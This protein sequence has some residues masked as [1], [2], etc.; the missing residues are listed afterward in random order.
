M[1][2]GVLAGEIALHAKLGS[3][4]VGGALGLP[5]GRP[6]PLGGEC[7][8]SGTSRVERP[9][10]LVSL[11]PLRSHEL[12]SDPGDYDRPVFSCL[13]GSWRLSSHVNHVSG[14]SLPS[15]PKEFVK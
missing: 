4:N 3:K 14:L 8:T 7:T 6:G 11:R 13:Y 2:L 10:G 1:G 9:S 15:L 5:D 12:E